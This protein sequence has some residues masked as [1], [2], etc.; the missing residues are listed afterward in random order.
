MIMKY[1]K[2]YEEI[3][4]VIG[5]EI[6]G[7]QIIRV[8]L[9]DDWEGL[10]IDGEIIDQGHSLNIRDVLFVMVEKKLNLDGY[11]VGSLSIKKNGKYYELSEDDSDNMHMY[12]LPKNINEFIDAVHKLGYTTEFDAD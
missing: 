5:S 3:E 6:G 12:N 7:K 4:K 1:V 10:Y 8:V 2:K 11:V 9:A